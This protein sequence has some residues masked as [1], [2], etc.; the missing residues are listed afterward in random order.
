LAITL[1]QSVRIHRFSCVLL[2]TNSTVIT[3]N[4]FDLPKRKCC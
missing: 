2:Q 4:H 3:I 1:Q